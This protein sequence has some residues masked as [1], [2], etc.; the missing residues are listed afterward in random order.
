MVDTA[1]IDGWIAESNYQPYVTP[2]RRYHFTGKIRKARRRPGHY[3]KYSVLSTR[4][5]ELGNFRLVQAVL[6]GSQRLSLVT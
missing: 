3:T 5:G 1:M 4:L 6:A 2:V